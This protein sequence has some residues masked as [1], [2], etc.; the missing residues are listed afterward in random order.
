MQSHNSPLPPANT[1]G[2]FKL[3]FCT[4]VVISEN[5]AEL[6]FNEGVE[7]SSS[8]VE[9]TLGVLRSALSA[10]FCLL[11]NE[12]SSHSYDFQAQTAAGAI[13][14]LLAL[15]MVS[16]SPQTDIAT[17]SLTRLPRQTDWPMAVF[18]NREDALAWLIAMQQDGVSWGPL[19]KG[20]A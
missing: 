13:P 9:Q 20:S 6:L 14:D 7:V 15:A 4:I 10:P 16:Y 12:R 19:S 2:I 3:G 1:P 11:V 5:T 8:M 17:D 18:P